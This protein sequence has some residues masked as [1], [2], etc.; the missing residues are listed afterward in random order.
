MAF[1]VVTPFLG[2]LAA[3]TG[4]LAL[5]WVTAGPMPAIAGGIIT[6]LVIKGAWALFRT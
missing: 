4:V 1:G 6:L 5:V 3:T 2:L